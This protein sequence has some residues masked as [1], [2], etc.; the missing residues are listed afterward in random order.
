MLDRDHDAVCLY[1]IISKHIIMKKG[2]FGMLFGQ[3]K[4][5]IIF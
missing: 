1:C 3:D 2:A 5:L 4:V